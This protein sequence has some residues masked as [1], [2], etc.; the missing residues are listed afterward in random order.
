MNRLPLVLVVACFTLALAG[1][2]DYAPAYKKDLLSFDEGLV[3]SWFAEFRSTD[4][5]IEK[6][7]RIPVRIERR[8]A[9]VTGGRLG[10]FNK[11]DAKDP[12]SAKVPTPAYRF[13]V[14]WGPDEEGVTGQR[15]Y[16]AVLLKIEDT[17]LLAYQ[18][19]RDDPLI[20]DGFGDVLPVHKVIWINRLGDSL[21]VKSMRHEVV[22]LPD[23][24]P[25]YG[26]SGEARLPPAEGKWLVVDPDRLTEVLKLAVRTPDIWSEGMILKRE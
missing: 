12:S 26:E 17:T 2:I 19:A 7:T 6:S 20:K 15:A 8:D 5:G 25:L 16:E 1:C 22:W 23:V 24:K 14:T 21:S 10:E 4:N 13:V 18:I 3:G 9:Q 11:S